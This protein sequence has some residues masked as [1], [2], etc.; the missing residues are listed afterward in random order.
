MKLVRLLAIAAALV[1]GCK[2]EAIESLEATR[3]SVCACHDAT[4]VNAAMNKLV[5]RPTKYKRKAELLAR[6]ITDCM[7]R[8]YRTS[9]AAPS[10][11]A[12][13]EDAAPEDASPTPPTPP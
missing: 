12:A 5:D 3:D 10:V 11:D 1:V 8:I 13:P 6:D 4:C 2:D 9:D 7:A